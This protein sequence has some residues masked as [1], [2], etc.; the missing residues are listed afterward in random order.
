MQEGF[1]AND[2]ARRR[3]RDDSDSSD[4]PT[5]GE[6][7]TD[8]TVVLGWTQLFETGLGAG[9]RASTSPCVVSFEVVNQPRMMW[10]LRTF[11]IN[12]ALTT[13]ALVSNDSRSRILDLAVA[14]IDI[15]GESAVRVNHIAADAGVT[16]PVIYH[17]FGSRDGL[18]IAAQVT[19]YARRPL[20][21][22]KWIQDEIAKCATRD[23]LREVFH[24]TWTRIVSGRMDSRW[25]RASALGSAFGRP[26]LEVAIAAAQDEIVDELY[27]I[28]E[29]CR[30]RGWFRPGIDLRSTVAWQHSLLIGRIYV[31]RG[32]A[33]V[34][35]QEWDRL[36][37]EA[38]SNAFFG[39]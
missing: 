26:E 28:L 25:A 15:G 14:A 34:D 38:L 33:S 23:E 9:S 12:Q 2:I 31:E 30:E 39:G 19:R 5:V 6:R 10:R 27:D 32:Q 3:K 1:D 36:T 37:F 29:P 8:Q 18:V 17:H 22:L 7:A 16:P 11:G 24:A 21:D 35:V 13:L 4:D 20:S